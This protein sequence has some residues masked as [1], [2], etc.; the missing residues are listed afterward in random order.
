MVLQRDHVM[1]ALRRVIS[2]EWASRDVEQWA[3]LLEGRDDVDLERGH[4]STLKE[5]IF[6]LANTGTQGRIDRAQAQSLIERLSVT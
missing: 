1:A 6:E 5:I 4:E 2:G 3:D